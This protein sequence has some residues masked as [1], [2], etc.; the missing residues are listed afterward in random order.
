VPAALACGMALAQAPAQESR[1]AESRSLHHRVPVHVQGVG[2]WKRYEPADVP[3]GVT[4]EYPQN[5][6]AGAERGRQ[7]PY[8]QV[9]ILGPRNPEDTFSATLVVRKL[10][11]RTAGG[12]HE[13][14]DALLR[15]RRRQYEARQRL[16]TFEETQRTLLDRR[17][18]QLQ[19]AYAATIPTAQDQTKTLTTR[20]QVVIVSLDVGDHLYELT[21]EAD[22]DE[23]SLYQPVFEHLLETLRLG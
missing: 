3:L 15:A 8:W 4:F 16:V 9:I 7:Q 10:P 22:A 19:F 5:W 20:L 18:Q 6:V 23:F 11:K 17:A 12:V 14:L 1:M 2:P 21:Y 13:D